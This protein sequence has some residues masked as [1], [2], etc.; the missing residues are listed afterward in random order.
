MQHLGAVL[1]YSVLDFL[2]VETILAARLVCKALRRAI[3]DAGALSKAAERS[4]SYPDLLL[5]YCLN[6]RNPRA[7][8]LPREAAQEAAQEA[9][10]EATRGAARETSRELFARIG[11]G[12]V[13]A[14]AIK[15]ALALSRLD[16]LKWL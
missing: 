9:A 2:G 16:I 5:K 4:G 6:A 13:T 14:P 11:V 1:R 15:A 3:A 12:D 8:V 10:R 7:E